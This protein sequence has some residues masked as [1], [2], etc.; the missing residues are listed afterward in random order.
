MSVSQ[1][2]KLINAVSFTGIAFSIALSIYFYRLGVFQDMASLRHLVGNSTIAG[3]LV[4]ILIQ[5]I[6]VIIPILPGGISL[7]AGVL[8]FGPYWGFLYNYLGICLG[9]IILFLLGRHYGKP[10]IS[11][12][13][14]E[15]VY[16]KYSHWLE[17][18]RRFEKMFSLAIFLPIAPDDALCLMASLTNI[19]FKKYT[20]IILLAKPASIFLYSFALLHGGQ[21]LSSLLTH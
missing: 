21:L 3:P 4:F 12:L 18:D 17:N 2:K 14:S 15:K 16:R 10:F 20:A 1:S 9:S 8:I 6:Q 5:M 13:V 19:S 11:H 7:A